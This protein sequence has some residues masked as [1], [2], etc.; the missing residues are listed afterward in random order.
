[1]AKPDGRPF[2]TSGDKRGETGEALRYLRDNLPK[3][4]FEGLRFP[5]R[6]LSKHDAELIVKQWREENK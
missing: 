2:M 6:K 5:V 3:E 1:M 4:V